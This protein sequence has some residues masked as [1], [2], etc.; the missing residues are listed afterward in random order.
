MASQ[1]ATLRYRFEHRVFP[2]L[3]YDD[4]LTVMENLEAAESDYMAFLW[5]KFLELQ[6]ISDDLQ[7]QPIVFTEEDFDVQIG[8]QNELRYAIIKMPKATS[9]LQ[10][11]R[12]G[13]VLS[14]DGKYR[15]YYTVERMESGDYALCGWTF[16]EDELC[17]NNYGKIAKSE[18]KI[19]KKMFHEMVSPKKD[20]T[21][22]VQIKNW[23]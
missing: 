16:E 10:C 12:I 19:A 6:D 9:A 15:N 22:S 21:G 11:S 7:E 1:N 3:F 5:E 20:K 13:I 18:E 14:Q 23:L 8:E 2:Y 4:P 17:H